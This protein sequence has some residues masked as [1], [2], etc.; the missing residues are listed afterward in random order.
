M[1][2]SYKTK[3]RAIQCSIKQ[4]ISIWCDPHTHIHKGFGTS[5]QNALNSYF[6]NVVQLSFPF[7][8]SFWIYGVIQNMA[9][10]IVTFLVYFK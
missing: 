2:W 9:T 3:I 4:L 6:R 5:K 8:I 7:S 10:P 1:L